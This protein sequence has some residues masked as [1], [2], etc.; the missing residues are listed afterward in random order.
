MGSGGKGGESAKAM[1]CRT[2]VCFGLWLQAVYFDISK[3]SKRVSND[4]RS[5]G[6]LWVDMMPERLIQER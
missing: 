2:M 3:L 5:A 6:R 4:G 1:G